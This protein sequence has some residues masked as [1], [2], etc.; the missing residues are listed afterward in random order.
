MTSRSGPFTCSF[1]PQEESE[2]SGTLLTVAASGSKQMSIQIETQ[3]GER[4][5]YYDGKFVNEIEGATYRYLISGVSTAD[6]VMVFLPAGIED[7]S[8]DVDVIDIPTPADTPPIAPAEGEIEGSPPE[9]EQEQDTTQQFSLLILDDEKS[10]QIEADVVIEKAD[11]E[12]EIVETVIE[13][14]NRL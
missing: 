9:Q 2:E 12:Q 7:F 13:I 11:V 5:G 4:L 14:N 1:C 6:P 3:T 8:A 10:V